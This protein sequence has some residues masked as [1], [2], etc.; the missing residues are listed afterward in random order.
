MLFRS[1]TGQKSRAVVMDA[2]MKFLG[3]REFY[4]QELLEIPTGLHFKIP[5]E[6]VKTILDSFVPEVE[7]APSSS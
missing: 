7:Q 6:T 3:I 1:T 2:K 4:P 5:P